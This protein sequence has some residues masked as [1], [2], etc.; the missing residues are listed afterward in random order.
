MNEFPFAD[1]SMFRK[2]MYFY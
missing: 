2:E 1:N